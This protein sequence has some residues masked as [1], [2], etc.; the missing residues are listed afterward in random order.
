M[1]RCRAAGYLRFTGGLAVA[2]TDL[3]AVY[4]FGFYAMCCVG[5]QHGVAFLDMVQR[6]LPA[7]TDFLA[8]GYQSGA[9]VFD[10]S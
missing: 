3:V 7:A 9:T 4:P 2:G 5:K 10:E 1:G 6:I 8:D